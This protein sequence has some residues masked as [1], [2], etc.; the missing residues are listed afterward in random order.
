VRKAGLAL[1]MV[2]AVAPL[3]A[4]A[5]RHPEAGLRQP[6]RHGCVA[7]RSLAGC[8]R[9][10]ALKGASWVTVAPDGRN[11]YVG[12]DRGNS[13]AAFARDPRT[14]ALRQLRGRTGCVSQAGS[15][16][17]RAGRALRLARP[18]AVSPDGRSVYAGTLDG[19]AVFSR[20]RGGGLRQLP[21][22]RGCVAQSGVQGCALGR[23]VANVRALTVAPD[24]HR[25]YVAA[26]GSDAVAVFARSQRSG[27]LHQLPGAAGCI[28]ERPL[29]GCGHGRGIDGG[30]GV[31]LS[32]D[33][34][35]VYVAAED[36]DSVAIFAR[37]RGGGLTQLPGPAGCLQRLGKDGC[38]QLVTLS[39]PHH[40]LI[41]RDGRFVYVASGK[42]GAVAILRRDGRTGRLSGVPGRRGCVQSPPRP[43]CSAGRALRGAHSL[44]LSAGDRL[45]YAVGRDDHAI[46]VLARD[47]RTG[48]LAQLPGRRGCIGRAAVSSCAPAHG[49]RGVHSVAASP[50]GRDLYAASELD[51]ALVT[52][53]VGG[54]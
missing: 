27:V 45:L 4:A 23:G 40:I 19:V 3:V 13:V 48:A 1:L 20:G 10:R 53:A 37:S 52:L 42:I 12:A 24:G 22:R 54:G 47:P 26:R 36:G 32:P 30:R 2:V 5:R 6:A 35:F 49:L 25:L 43:R 51:D 38:A 29:P 8:D 39:S 50:D 18:V 41:T 33:R 7:E 31:V 16:G 11:V 14:G 28:A 9:G 17:C 34:R 46:A 15:M 21:G 44:A